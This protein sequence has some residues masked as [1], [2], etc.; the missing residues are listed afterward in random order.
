VKAEE[1]SLT[2]VVAVGDGLYVLTCH[3]IEILL[4]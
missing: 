4:P 3:F 1:I 2:A